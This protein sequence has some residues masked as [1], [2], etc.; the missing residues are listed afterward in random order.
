MGG[1]SRRRSDPWS[2]VFPKLNHF[3]CS[4]S[5]HAIG[6]KRGLRELHSSGIRL[7]D[8]HVDGIE[9]EKARVFADWRAFPEGRTAAGPVVIRDYP[10]RK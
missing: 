8:S 3:P 1:L 2:R 7:T 4:F 6:L 10:S 9:K 5:N